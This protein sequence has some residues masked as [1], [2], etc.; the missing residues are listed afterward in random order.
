MSGIARDGLNL[1]VLEP[2]V[3]RGYLAQAI[4]TARDAEIGGL[5]SRVMEEHHVARFMRCL[6]DGHAI[7][8]RVFAERMASEAIRNRDA[9]VLRLGLIALLLSWHGPDSRETLMVFP[10]FYDAVRRMGLDL[11]LLVASIRETIGDQLAAPF[12]EFLQR[13]ESDKSLQ[14]M[15]YAEGADNDGFRYQRNW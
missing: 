3:N 13:S 14:A 7:V 1:D 4:P 10:I 9:A 6:Q 15:G 11:T 12:V 5:L 8:L 2:A